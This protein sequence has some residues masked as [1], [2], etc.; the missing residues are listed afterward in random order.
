MKTVQIAQLNKGRASSH[1]FHKSGTSILA[2]GTEIDDNALAALSHAGIEELIE[3]SPFENISEFIFSCKYDKRTVSSLVIGEKT[4]S[5]IFDAKGTLLIDVG[6]VITKKIPATFESR[7]FSQIFLKKQPQELMMDQVMAYRRHFD[8]ISQPGRTGEDLRKLEIGIQPQ[9]VIRDKNLF[10]ERGMA[11]AQIEEVVPKGEPMEKLSVEHE[12]LELRTEE[13]KEEFTQIHADISK[14]FT[15]LIGRYTA[16]HE[17]EAQVLGALASKLIGA[18]LHDRTLFL[19]LANRVDDDGSHMIIHHPLN[20]TV[21]A[22]NIGTVMGYDKEQILELAIGSFLHN[23]GMLQVP[24]KILNKQG[25]LTSPERLAVKKH[26]LYGINLLQKVKNLPMSVPFIAYQ[27]HERING[28]GYPKGRGGDFIHPFAKIVG[29]ADV[30]CALTGDRPQRKGLIPYVAMES[31]I[32]LCSKGELDGDVVRALLKHMSLFPIGSWVELENGNLGKV[33]DTN[34]ND[35][36]NPIISVMY[37]DNKRVDHHRI[38]L[39]EEGIKIKKAFDGRP[40]Q[41]DIMEGF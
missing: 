7:G 29:V 19:N 17:I 9:R 37:K 25:K 40:L 23:V 24:N 38:N 20:V 30:F 15:K 16:S 41:N 11:L 27:A 26:A 31:V 10:T 35:F 36:T 34:E 5:P 39:K 21:L 18:S 28:S 4:T 13:Q 33:V 14:K 6:V 2:P 3:L 12:K 1:Y 8:K 32:R 22:I